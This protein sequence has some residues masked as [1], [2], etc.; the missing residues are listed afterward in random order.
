MAKY[1]HALPQANGTFCLTDGGLE[2]TLVF[3]EGLDLPEFAA[4]PLIR[5]GE[6]REILRTYMERYIAIAQTHGTGFVMET[7]TWRASPDYAKKLGVSLDELN[8]LNR[9]A[10]GDLVTLRNKYETRVTPMVISG[11]I[12]PRRDRYQADT[13][14][15]VDEASAYHC[16]QI[17]VFSETEADM[18][19]AITLTNPNE[20]SGIVHAAQTFGMPSVIGFTVETDGKL[21]TGQSLE[22]AIDI[23]DTETAGGPAY[24]M[25]NCA[26]P[27]HFG[28]ELAGGGVRGDNWVNRIKGLRANASCMSHEE[29]DNAEELDRGNP[30]ELGE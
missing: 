16:R 14:M 22:E 11:N 19:T 23:V 8:T 18:V 10:V 24:Y 3:L 27:S 12:G 15:S 20:A 5:T 7:P 30:E 9:I 29:L 25:I 4:F 13:A 2:T 17:F 21:P 28:A 1:R 26:H 6:G